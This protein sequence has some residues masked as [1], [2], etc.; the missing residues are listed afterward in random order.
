MKRHGCRV[1]VG[2]TFATGS[3]DVCGGFPREGSA[4]GG[5]TLVFDETT[6]DEDSSPTGIHS[7]C[8]QVSP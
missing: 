6:H 7:G 3:V 1:I 5:P 4:R 2:L 8:V